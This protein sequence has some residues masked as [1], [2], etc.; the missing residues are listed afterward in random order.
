LQGLNSSI[1]SPFQSYAETTLGSEPETIGK[2]DGVWLSL[3]LPAIQ[4]Q[5]ALEKKNP[6]AALNALQAASP[7]ELGANCVRRQYFLPLSRV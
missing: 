3:W 5:K 7:I 4:A 2:T 6:A 1:S